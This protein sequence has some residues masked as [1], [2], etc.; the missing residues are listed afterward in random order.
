MKNK[1]NAIVVSH[2]SKSYGLTRAVHDLSFHINKGEIFGLLGHN[3]AG[4]TT[5]IEC[6]LGT[7]KMDSG[8]INILGYK[9]DQQRKELFHHIGI[10]FQEFAYPSR[11]KVNEVCRL[12]AALYKHSRNCNYKNLLVEF[13]LSKRYK[14]YIHTLSG[15]ERQ[16]LS[17]LLAVLH[18]P[19]VLILDE[20][21]TGL[22][23]EARHLVWDTIKQLQEKGTT[24]LLTSHYMEEVNYLCDRIAILN[25]GK[26]MCLDT[27]QML[28]EAT[29]S[30]NLE[31]TY[32][33][34]TNK[35]VM[36]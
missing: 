15:G 5:T 2:L 9:P 6:M 4:K 28:I 7:K 10:Q 21:T 1:E 14:H 20:L 22:D 23:P 36:I 33:Y 25:K 35:E 11:L 12:T 19:K 34:Y 16:K 24:I 26:L 30:K 18:N 27:P 31:E 8:M 29:H 32:L 17:I 13:D 3:G